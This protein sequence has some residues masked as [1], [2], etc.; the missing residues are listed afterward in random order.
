VNLEEIRATLDPIDA[1]TWIVGGGLRDALL[2]RT[3]ADVD[4]AIAGDAQAAA[5][6]MARAHGA[7]RFTLSAAFGSWRVQGG[8]LPYTVD[9]T[10]LQG[11]TLTE[12]LARRDLTINALAMPARGDAEIVDLHGGRD[13]LANRV[14]RQVTLTAFRAD[15]VRL[16]RVAR[17]ATQLGF[18]VDPATRATAQADAHLLW[19]CPGERLREELGRMLRLDDPA[20]AVLGLDDI[21]VL[22]VLVPELEQARGLDQSEYHQHDVL[23]HTLEVVQRAAALVRDPEPVFRSLTARILEVFAEPLADDLTRG[24]AL[25]W[26]ALL[27]DM[28]KAQ[29]KGVT[30]QGRVTFFGHD[31]LGAAGA[32]ALLR[33]LRAAT[34]LREATVHCVR[35]HLALGFLVHRQPLSLRDMDR[36]LRATNPVE[37]E[38]IVL[39]VADRLATNGPR[40]RESAITRHLALAR[41]VM[42][43]HFELVDRGPIRPPINGAQIAAALGRPPGAW[44]SELL[45]ALREEQLVRVINSEKALDFAQNWSERHPT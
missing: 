17:L 39:S 14:L 21:G 28:A 42:G 34:R 6:A 41:Q 12:D 23:G 43:T 1:P 37:V 4:L 40:T 20:S 5:K 18:T 2:G 45:M 19:T 38:L 26:P 32:D 35:H 25:V 16:L 27:H 8:R 29:T 33:E 9:I 7:G 44:L 11:A 24:Q 30:P 3:V 31:R 15:P 13:D 10:P 22:G 36:Y